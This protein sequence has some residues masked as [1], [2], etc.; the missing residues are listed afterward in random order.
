[1]NA[2]LDTCWVNAHGKLLP[3]GILPIY[4][5]ASLAE[6]EELLLRAY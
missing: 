2:G 6:L 1:M 5:V 4:Q 3:E